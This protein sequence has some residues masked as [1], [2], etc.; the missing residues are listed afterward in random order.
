MDSPLQITLRDVPRSPVLEEAIRDRAMKLER[1]FADILNCRVSVS[2]AEQS[3]H[4]HGA[5][6]VR[7]ELHVPGQAIVTFGMNKDASAAVREAF[8]H[9][10]RQLQEYARRLRGDVRRH[11][12]AA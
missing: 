9:A 1:F 3:K 2:V 12:S 6:N 8:D 4:R 7:V 11:Q 5:L 10:A